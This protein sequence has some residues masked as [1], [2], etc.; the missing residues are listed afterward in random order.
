M[1]TFPSQALKAGEAALQKARVSWQQNRF[2][3]FR[4]GVGLLLGFDSMMIY[5]LFPV[6]AIWDMAVSSRFF[7]GCWNWGTVWFLRVEDD[8]SNFSLQCFKRLST[9][10]MDE[11]KSSLQG[12]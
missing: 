2:F 8:G 9:L 10:A 5:I 4:G 12:G 3:F 1:V 11:Q 6:C 7:F